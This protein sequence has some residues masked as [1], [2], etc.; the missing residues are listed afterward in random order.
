MIDGDDCIYAYSRVSGKNSG[1]TRGLA[2]S[3]ALHVLA[4][5]ALSF[6]AVAPRNFFPTII[7]TS[8]INETPGD[9]PELVVF[10]TV[11]E[12]QPAEQAQSKTVAV[13]TLTEIFSPSSRYV[14]AHVSKRRARSH[15]AVAEIQQPK[16][17]L[18]EPVSD[19][20]AKTTT[21]KRTLAAIQSRVKSA[22][23]S[24]GRVQFSLVWAGRNDLDLHVI[25]PSGERVFFHNKDSKCYAELDIDMNARPD[26]EAP[27][28]NIHWPKSR[29]PEGRY[30]I[31]VHYYR[32]HV[33]STGVP[34]KLMIKR[35]DRTRI[36]DGIANRD[37]D[38][39]VHRTLYIAPHVQGYERSQR[40]QSY[41]DKQRREEDDATEQM[42]WAITRGSTNTSLAAIVL[43]YPHTNAAVDAIRMLS[44][45]KTQVS[46]LPLERSPTTAFTSHS[47][48]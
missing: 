27:V 22:G 46:S 30:T 24:S 48:R 34:Y 9:E 8:S 2:V 38:Y 45:R 23:G 36:V 7:T 5:A 35:A 25:A 12:I 4:V 6:V 47:Q 33:P 29:A 11:D 32:K 42:K 10:S 14:K 3:I 37:N 17:D 1:C 39:C 21:E 44:Q 15:V 43:N 31:L 41:I 40:V 20:N 18:T 26:C 28:E 13:S 19:P 16:V